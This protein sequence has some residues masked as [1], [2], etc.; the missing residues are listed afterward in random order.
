M[1]KIFIPHE[2]KTLSIDTEKKIFQI[3][4]EEFGKDCAGFTITCKSYKDFDIRIEIDATVK[5]VSIREGECTSETEH[6]V[7]ESWYSVRKN[8]ADD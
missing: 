4:G 3:N 8:C 2:L 5:F 6:P 7:R 1:S